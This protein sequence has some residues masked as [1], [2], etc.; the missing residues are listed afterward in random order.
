MR[1]RLLL[2]RRPRIDTAGT[3]IITDPV[4]GGIIH[5]RTI[6][7]SVVNDGGVDIRHRRIIPEMPTYPAAAGISRAEI[8]ASVINAAIEA[9]MRAPI[10]AIPRVDPIYITP[11]T[12]RPQEADLR[13]FSPITRDPK[14]SIIIIIRPISRDPQIP[15]NGT[16]RLR[17]DGND[18]R[19]DMN[20]DADAKH[21]R[22]S[23]L[24]RQTAD[25]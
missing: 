12:G 1:S 16:D 5:Y 8:A 18:G 22:I 4:G 25:S 7:I 24:N 6:D 17:I 23:P 20:A 11:I 9:D 21:L 14:I 13:R 19:P 15:V 2:R 3:A 10:S